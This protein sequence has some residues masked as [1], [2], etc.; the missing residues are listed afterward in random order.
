MAGRKTKR[1]LDEILIAEGLITEA[2]ILEALK[3]QKAEGGR[4]GSQLLYLGYID[5]PT[6]VQALAK[7]GECEGVVLSK[8]EI[9]DIIIKMIPKKVAIARRAVPFDYDI[10]NNILKIACHDPG[11][12]DVINELRFV[13]R[14]KN[15]KLY[16]EVEAV[17]NKTIAN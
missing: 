2:Q 16:V 6:L 3:G 10:E 15:I 17:I 1:R 11:D 8:L 9:P 13:T 14:G 5:E 4:F 7:Q 12:E